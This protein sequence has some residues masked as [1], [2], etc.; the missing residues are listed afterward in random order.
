MKLQDCLFS[1][2]F[3][4]E[5]DS[6]FKK[7]NIKVRNRTKLYLVGYEWKAY[8]VENIGFNPALVISPRY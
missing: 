8:R 2:D 4:I 7:F 6:I 1:D 5:N 3:H